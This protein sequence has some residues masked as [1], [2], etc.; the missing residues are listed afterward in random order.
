MI[1]HYIKIAWRN[2]LKYK[3]QSIIS[4]LG[5]AI[6]FAA[7]A[8]TMS[9]IRYDMGYDKHIYEADR[10]YKVLKADKKKEGGF[11]FRLPDAM[12]SYLENLPEVEAV[13]AIDT[14]IGRFRANNVTYIENA[15]HMLADTSFFKVFYPDIKIKYPTEIGESSGTYNI[16]SASAAEKAGIKNADVGLFK[17]EL[18]ANLLA[19]IDG[20]DSKQTNVPFDEMTVKPIKLDAECPW[21]Y[22]ARSMYIRVKKGVNINILAS[23]IDTLYIEGS[24]QGVMSYKLVPLKDVRTKYPEDKAKIRYNHLR[25]FVVVSILVILS[26]LF[27]YLMLFINKIKIRSRELALRKVNG[28][29]NRRLITLL[30]VE[31]GIILV[32][33]LFLG[34][35]FIELLYNP[36]ITLSEISAS[37]GFMFKESFMY[38]IL[39]FAFFVL[40]ALVPTYIFMRKSVSEIINPQAKSFVGVKNSFTLTSLFLQFI[41][42][43]LLIF[44]TIV[45]LLQFKKLNSNDIGFDRF[46]IISFSGNISFTKNELLKIPGIEDV[47]FFDGQFLPRGGHSSFDVKSENGEMINTEMIRIH[48]PNFIDFFKINI[49]EGRNFHFGEMNAYLIN[50]TAK[51][52]Y[53]FKDPIGKSIN[54]HT[55]IGVIADMYVDSPLMPVIPTTLQLN[56]YMSDAARLKEDGTYE[57]IREPLPAS[58]EESESK[59]H[60]SFAYKY[61]PERK[62]IIEQTITDIFEKDGGRLSRFNNLESVYEEYTKSE[63]YLLI[64]LS[65]MTGVAILISLFGI[66]S[67]VTLSC[68]E[69]RKEIALRKV[70]GAQMR[71]ILF[72]FYRQYLILSVASCIVAFPIGIYVMQ[73][74]LEQYTRRIKMEWW[75][76]AG[77]FVCITLIVLLGVLYRVW[78]TARENPSEVLKSQ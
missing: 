2:L 69:K 31:M 22:Q 66:Y 61:M 67:M 23:K 73:Q 5:L 75:L 49:L 29:S 60:N 51:R 19:I 24:M 56:D 40:V 70:N 13:T 15:N 26:A 16:L 30:I 64:M 12:A 25:I 77:T 17:T 72:L 37:K 62:E 53:G 14:D 58:M 45:F 10:V 55:I 34:G 9:W 57:Y 21:C 59:V 78:K 18:D 32:I 4:I 36:F 54:N 38:A 39:L 52:A 43:I 3:T 1:I 35:L 28:S 20:V 68:N 48:E 71:D 41:T 65:F 8:F 42:S 33:S 6:G 76:F 11:N 46:N 50:E 27:N 63:Y 74:W 7:F 47:I 44:C